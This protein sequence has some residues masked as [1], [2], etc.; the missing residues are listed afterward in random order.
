MSGEDNYRT[1]EFPFEFAFRRRRRRREYRRAAAAGVRWTRSGVAH[2]MGYY[3]GEIF[4]DNCVNMNGAPRMRTPSRRSGARSCHA[5]GGMAAR[6]PPVGVLRSAAHR[7]AESR[8]WGV[9][10]IAVHRAF[11]LGLGARHRGIVELS[12]GVIRCVTVF[13]CYSS[14]SS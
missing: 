12:E 13:A 7:R 8:F 4:F 1:A 10:I 2:Y 14:S 3:L 6:G 9:F 11:V 5:P